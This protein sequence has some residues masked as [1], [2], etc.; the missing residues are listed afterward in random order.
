MKAENNLIN[1]KDRLPETSKPV[2]CLW[3]KNAQCIAFYTKGHEIEF[4]DDDFG[5]SRELDPEEERRGCLLLKA[6]WYEECEQVR[7]MYDHHFISRDV[8]QWQPLPEP[9]NNL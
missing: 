4:D 8:T 1:V 2:L 6:G 7:S 9:P 5:D 3:G